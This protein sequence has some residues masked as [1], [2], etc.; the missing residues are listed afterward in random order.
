MDCYLIKQMWPKSI[1]IE[2]MLAGFGEKY[3]I[4]KL[5]GFVERWFKLFCKNPWKRYGTRAGFHI[6]QISLDPKTFH[7]FPLLNSG[8]SEPLKEMWDYLNK[9]ISKD[10]F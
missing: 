2:L 10:V 1:L 5:G 7:R 8:F 4:Q 3:D 9:N 6:E